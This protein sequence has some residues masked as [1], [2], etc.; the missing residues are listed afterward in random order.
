MWYPGIRLGLTSGLKSQ[1]ERFVS[2]HTQT[3]TVGDAQIKDT[4]LRMAENNLS[5]VIHELVFDG[6]FLNG[7]GHDPLHPSSIHPSQEPLIVVVNPEALQ[8]H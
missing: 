3:Q 7:M 4:V 2:L 8:T 5:S 1:E 6:K